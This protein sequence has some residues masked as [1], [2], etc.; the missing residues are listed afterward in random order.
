MPGDEDPQAL[1]V[2]DAAEILDLRHT[3]G[4][5]L[6]HLPRAQR[7]VVELAYYG[8]LTQGEIAQH[9]GEPLGTIKT[10]T[11]TAL[12]RLRTALRPYFDPVAEDEDAR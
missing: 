6:H 8:G 2:A 11:R 7:Q 4:A 12:E 3:V 1:S 5:A 9:L 10:R